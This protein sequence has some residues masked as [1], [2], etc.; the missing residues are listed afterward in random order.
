MHAP[1]CFRRG[2]GA[3]TH[4]LILINKRGHLIIWGAFQILRL[5]SFQVDKLG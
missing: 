1:T 4:V 3:S 5:F 2:T